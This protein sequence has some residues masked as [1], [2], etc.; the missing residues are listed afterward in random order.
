[1]K[2]RILIIGAGWEQKPLIEKAIEVGCYVITT[3]PTV[4]SDNSLGNINFV[5]NPFNLTELSN[6]IEYS[7]PEAIISDACDYSMFAQAL[8][9]RKYNMFG[10]SATTIQILSNK[11]LQREMARKIKVKQPDYRLCETYKDVMKATNELSYPLILKPLFNRGG[12][13]V[14]K[15]SNKKELDAAYLDTLTNSGSKSILIEK[16]IGKSVI[17]VEGLYSDKYY[18]LTYSTKKK[19]WKYSDNA[20]ELQYPGELTK[21]LE[22]KI[23][24]ITKQLVKAFNINRGLIHTEYI[25]EDNEVYFLEIHNRGSGVLVSSKI[26]P[27]LTNIDISDFLIRQS[28]GEQTS[29]KP[30]YTGKHTILHFFDFGQGTVSDISGIRE[31]RNINNIV[32]FRLNFTIGDKLYDVKTAVDRHGFVIVKGDSHQECLN[33][34]NDIDNTLK[35]KFKEP[36]NQN[37]R[38]RKIY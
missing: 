1:M 22:D 29:I 17:T 11:F 3:T 14:N 10:P 7:K 24:S 34:I 27:I 28:F 32:H 4:D 26:L 36:I 5:V 25:I 12:I 19:H 35:I 30:N 15:I 23:Y 18:N 31:I 16:Y 33:L 2:K 6:I 21:E 38:I 9:A 8:L 20:M 37:E 13:G